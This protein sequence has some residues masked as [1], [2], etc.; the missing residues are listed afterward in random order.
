MSVRISP[1]SGLRRAGAD[2]QKRDKAEWLV[3]EQAWA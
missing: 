2:V 3:G 1:A